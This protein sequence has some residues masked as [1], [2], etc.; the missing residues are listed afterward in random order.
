MTSKSTYTNY[1]SS[2]YFIFKKSSN[3][4]N[5]SK[6]I[7]F[8]FINFFIM[9]YTNF[10][11]LSEF[12]IQKS[13]FEFFMNTFIRNI[14][15]F[16]RNIMSINEFI[17]VIFERFDRFIFD[18]VYEF[19][20]VFFERIQWLYQFFSTKHCIFVEFKIKYDESN[21]ICCHI[22][23]INI[24]INDMID[25]YF[26]KRHIRLTFA[27]EWFCR[28]KNEIMINIQTKHNEKNRIEI[29]KKTCKISTTTTT[30]NRTNSHREKTKKNRLTIFACKRCSTK[31][32]NNIKLHIHV[33][34]HHQKKFIK[35]TVTSRNAWCNNGCNSCWFLERCVREDIYMLA[36][37]A[38][39]ALAALRLP[40]DIS[41]VSL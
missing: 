33:Q 40:R 13:T 35:S 3:F 17:R 19:R 26:L 11:S 7:F 22:C 1:N 8:A 32:F 18:N 12:I 25:Q 10:S 28:N 30:T 5:L 16:T 36:M 15:F 31:F 38:L 21:K 4:S 41:G 34:N 9:I 29:E 39:A 24:N 2:T 20:Q 23:D 27:C 14:L 6:S 37:A